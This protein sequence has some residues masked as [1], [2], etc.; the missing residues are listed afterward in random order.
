MQNVSAESSAVGALRAKA[1][2]RYLGIAESSFWRWVKEN[3][4]PQGI[5]LGN[6]CTIWRVS[7]LESFLS[8]ACNGQRAA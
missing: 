2:A 6:R 3:R 5:R 1:A 8:A 7:D 4:L